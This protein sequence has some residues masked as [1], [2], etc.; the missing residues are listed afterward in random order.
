MTDET[1]TFFDSFST[2]P[3]ENSLL[4]VLSKDSSLLTDALDSILESD[5][6]KDCDYPL[7]TEINEDFRLTDYIVDNL[8]GHGD[9]SV[10]EDTFSNFS[11]TSECSVVSLGHDH[12]Y[13]QKPP[14]VSKTLVFKDGKA[15]VK[16]SSERR[17]DVPMENGFQSELTRVTGDE[18]PLVL[19][20]EDGGE[21]VC[22]C[23]C[24]RTRVCV[25]AHACT[26]TCM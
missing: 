19:Q 21:C 26:R 16:D 17:R 10:M 13:A 3:E 24:A 18:A 15:S 11:A 25:Q 14:I 22:V 7:P 12:S 6:Q 1:D 2:F 9:I 20:H 23:V 4:E 8:D 5:W